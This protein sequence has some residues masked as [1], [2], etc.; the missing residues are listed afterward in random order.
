MRSRRK[1]A[2][3]L[4][5]A[6]AVT[7]T[8]FLSGCSGRQAGGK[9]EINMVVQ[10]PE[11]V[12][13]LKELEEKFN[14]A[15]DDIHLTIDIPNDALTI[16]KTRFIRGDNPDIIGIGGD[17]HYSNFLDSGML[18]D[19]SDYEG[20]AEINAGYLAIG[21]ALE[22]I[23]MDGVY[24]VPYTANAA[25]ILYNRDMFLEYG[26]EIP[27]TWNEFT[28]LCDEIKAAGILP[29]YFGFKDSWTCLAPW[30]AMVADLA[31]ANICKL[32]NRGEATFT[33]H[34]REAADKMLHLLPYGQSDPFSFGYNDACT[35]FARGQSAM[36]TIG[37][38]AVPQIKSVNPDMSV[39]SFVFPASHNPEENILNSGVDLLFAVTKDCPYKEAA[40]RVL[41]FLL[42]DENVKAYIDNQNSVPCKTGDFALPSMLDG[43]SEYIRDGRMADYHDH[44]YPT[45]MSVD[46]L[47]QTHLIQQDTDKFLRNFDENW[48]R[49]NRDL[50]EKVRQYETDHPGSAWGEVN[51][52]ESRKQGE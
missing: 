11:A 42:E 27:Q 5:F 7:F 17:I 6:G 1:T 18:M 21:K 45:E 33:D 52:D 36:F 20:L 51:R 8:A 12:G 15:H 48:K 35:S 47:I 37:S 38:Y 34:Y 13:I 19:I 4:A 40:Y 29:M 9:T 32:V 23:P 46:A 22:F 10:K 30:N 39:D 3:Y 26:W 2:Y 31:P 25:G 50:I 28:A 44:Y 49:Y 41:D 43:V 14:A 24:G 16:I